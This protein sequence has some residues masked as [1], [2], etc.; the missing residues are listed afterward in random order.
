MRLYFRGD[1]AIYSREDRIY[2]KL[3]R[4][5]LLSL[6]GLFVSYQIGYLYIK[7]LLSNSCLL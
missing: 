5:G 6:L 1:P 3:D 4:Y 7:G 2:N